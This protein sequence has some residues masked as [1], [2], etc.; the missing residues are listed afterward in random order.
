VVENIYFPLKMI[1]F[2]IWAKKYPMEM[3]AAP[4]WYQTPQNSTNLVISKKRVSPRRN[5]RES[6]E[7]R[8]K[9]PKLCLSSIMTASKLAFFHKKNLFH[10]LTM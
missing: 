4:T 1:A 6:K 2:L 5:D 3:V 9:N 7:A 8:P 10:P